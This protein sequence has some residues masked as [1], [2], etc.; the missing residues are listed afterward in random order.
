MVSDLWFSAI[1]AG[2]IGVI[3]MSFWLKSFLQT[4]PA[5]IL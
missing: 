5:Y 4:R 2:F 3:E 1:R